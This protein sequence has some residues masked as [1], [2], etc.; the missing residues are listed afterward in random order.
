MSLN[1]TSVL[2]PRVHAPSWKLICST[3]KDDVVKK[4]ELLK[5]DLQG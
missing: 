5:N 3:P 1:S 2:N 4:V